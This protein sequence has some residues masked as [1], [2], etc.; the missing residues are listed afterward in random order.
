MSKEI[1]QPPRAEL[2]ISPQTLYSEGR[3]LNLFME[4]E[5]NEAPKNPAALDAEATLSGVSIPPKQTEKTAS[6]GSR[7][8]E[9]T[10]ERQQTVEEAWK[11]YDKWRQKNKEPIS[12]EQREM[13]KI[14]K[15]KGIPPATGGVEEGER[16]ERQGEEQRF[17]Q[18]WMRNLGTA[19]NSENFDQVEELIN[20]LN[21]DVT[22]SSEILRFIG[23]ASVT[24]KTKASYGYAVEYAIERLL[25]IADVDPRGRYPDFTWPQ[26]QNLSVLIHSVRDK[27]EKLFRYLT[28]L[29]ERRLVAHEV[30]RTIGRSRDEYKGIV[31]QHVGTEGFN[32]LENEIVGVATIQ[33]LYE[34]ALAHRVS[35]K[36]GWLDEKAFEEADEEVRTLLA[37]KNEKGL[38]EKVIS[39]A[40][41]GS[42]AVTRRLR[43][44]EIRRATAVGRSM[45]AA[46][47]R[48]TV[49]GI[50][51]DVPED[52]DVQLRSFDSEYIARVLGGLKAIGGRFLFP[53]PIS[54]KYLEGYM[55]QKRKIAAR[56]E[57]HYGE[58]LKDVIG[59]YGQSEEALI[60]L[61]TGV[62]DP[63]SSGWR[64][65]IMFLKQEEYASVV[66]PV[67]R[68]IT[69]G[70]YLDQEWGKARAKVDPKWKA[71][72]WEVWK[73]DI[74]ET[75]REKAEREKERRTEFSQVVKDQVKTQRLFLGTLLR[76]DHLTDELKAEIWKNV[77]DFLPSRIAAFFPEYRR[78]KINDAE[79]DELRLKLYLAEEQRV[80]EDA[81][82][83]RAGQTPTKRL[84][85]YFRE[86]EIGD[87]EAE[88]IK[89]LSDYGKEQAQ[90]LATM[91]FPFTPFLDD[92]PRT[93]W[94]KSSQADLYR[95][96][97]SDQDALT[98]A[99]NEHLEVVSNPAA[100][101]KELTEHFQK[102]EKALAIPLG[103]PTAQRFMEAPVVDTLEMRMMNRWTKWTGSLIMEVLRKPRSEIEKFNLDAHVAD[104]EEELAKELTDLA[105]AGVISSDVNIKDAEGR[106]QIQ[107]I[108][109]EVK[110]RRRDLFFRMIR[111]LLLLLP[112]EMV[113]EMFKT[114]APPEAI[115]AMR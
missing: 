45:A 23:E 105:A 41:G 47:Q 85:D 110:A 109:D 88:I 36:K 27:D 46:S 49:Y 53:T 84:E 75:G 13:E 35:R 78:S 25:G 102:M 69:I 58:K 65:N 7:P 92:V 68:R 80:T 18:E 1:Y 38:E 54:K 76:N 71:K 87:E 81:E 17:W 89:K 14:L 97:V 12:P 20:K 59:L 10:P 48:R 99:N 72:A 34:K 4:G 50:L 115:K 11:N 103:H 22:V 62:V 31:T 64:A 43:P 82:L 83:I 67:G 55:D 21:L 44:W 33:R 73:R 74:D 30:F 32:F 26:Q 113:I 61:H 15:N 86:N 66:D 114:V 106:T 63:K 100:P 96:L 79:W 90:A 108:K 2:T 91:I 111:I 16:A 3:G 77:A 28:H 5:A 104:D 112:A 93:A 95:I 70:E 57:R 9:I 29:R 39:A 101:M 98:E 107:R 42:T 37:R 6:L 40:D 60:Y 19:I 24:D 51:G 52:P 94:E 8:K 56:D